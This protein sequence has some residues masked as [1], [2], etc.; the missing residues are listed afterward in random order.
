IGAGNGFR[1]RH[2]ALTSS[3]EA[4]VTVC[5]TCRATQKGPHESARARLHDGGSV[6]PTRRLAGNGR[7]RQGLPWPHTSALSL[8]SPSSITCLRPVGCLGPDGSRPL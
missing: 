6:V 8:A 1:S 3:P 4:S 2:G 7:N 5:C